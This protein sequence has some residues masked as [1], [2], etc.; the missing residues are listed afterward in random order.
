MA[1]NYSEIII[2]EVLSSLTNNSDISICEQHT[3]DIRTIALKH[4]NLIYFNNQDDIY[5]LRNSLYEQYRIDAIVEVAKAIS[6]FN[7]K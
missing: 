2:D 7:K 1:K 5:I 6:I 3:D 4:L